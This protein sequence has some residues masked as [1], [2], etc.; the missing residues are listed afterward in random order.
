MVTPGSRADEGVPIESPLALFVPDTR[1]RRRQP[2]SIFLPALIPGVTSTGNYARTPS[3]LIAR[4]EDRL[5]RHTV[6]I[7][8]TRVAVTVEG[9]SEH[10]LATMFDWDFLLALFA[11]A[12]RGY[13]REDGY[14]HGVTWTLLCEAAGRRDMSQETLAAA[15]RAVRRW[16]GIRISTRLAISADPALLQPGAFQSRA[17]QW[18]GVMEREGAYPVAQFE[19]AAEPRQTA[20]GSIETRETIGLLWLNPVWLLHAR[21]GHTAWLN[22]ALHCALSRAVSKRLLQVG[23]L[24]VA[25]G[26]WRVGETWELPLSTAASMLGLTNPQ[27]ARLLASV[28]G[29]CEELAGHG[30]LTFEIVP[31]EGRRR[32]AQVRLQLGREFLTAEHYRAVDPA[33]PP[34]VQ[35]LLWHLAALGVKDTEARDW[36]R[37][38]AVAVRDALR[39]AYWLQVVHRG[40]TSPTGKETVR[41]W[42]A[43][44]KRA[45]AERWAYTYP[46]F[47]TWA[48]DL[49]TGRDT[50]D[51][52]A[53]PIEA[54]LRAFRPPVI[55][56]ESVTSATPSSA[57]R[58]LVSRADDTH[59][60]SA[61]DAGNP[62]LGSPA[63]NDVWS[64]ATARVLAEDGPFSAGWLG[65]TTAEIGDEPVVVVHVPNSFA[66][67]W[68]DKKVRPLLEAALSDLR[69]IPTTL[70]VR[71]AETPTSNGRPGDR[72]S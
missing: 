3:G 56:Q 31:K 67:S 51:L 42:G 65:D 38:D 17:R 20:S 19:F 30:A 69:G 59:D 5:L 23:T 25:R 45:I 4:E 72:P 33:D 8:G 41:H 32:E 34:S 37:S 61:P 62:V 49:L 64:Q 28:T 55:A 50:L 16:A 29:A 60:S 10:G 18:P 40:R 66:A 70:D 44:L 21:L 15:K 14:F 7:G 47:Q 58:A 22:V 2:L 39:Y 12:E 13:A 35:V 26:E 53:S 46:E 48:R 6:A 52:S 43:F 71:V 11:L 9:S 27:P 36:V 68:L 1:V 63:P 54:T 57:V 24:A